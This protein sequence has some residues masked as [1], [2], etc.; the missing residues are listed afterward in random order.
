MLNISVSINGIFKWLS[1]VIGLIGVEGIFAGASILGY[2]TIH[3]L[4]QKDVKKI[5]ANR[6]KKAREHLAELAKESAN[7]EK[8]TEDI[9]TKFQK[10]FEDEYSAAHAPLDTLRAVDFSF[11]LSSILFFAAALLD[12]AG[13]YLPSLQNLL[14]SPAEAEAFI[15]GIFLLAVGILNLQRIRRI[16]EGETDID[17]APF[18]VVISLGLVLVV[19]VY[20]LWI[21]GTIYYSLSNFGKALFYSSILPFFGIVIAI[22]TWDKQNW[23]TISGMIL[24]FAPYILLV[25]AFILSSLSIPFP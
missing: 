2:F 6:L 17:P 22:L 10:L 8:I 15:F 3:E 20:F 9:E 13:S 25:G 14:L 7:S 19:D 16:T 18:N 24:M 1:L 23:K 4:A 21:T 12:W 5:H 11:L